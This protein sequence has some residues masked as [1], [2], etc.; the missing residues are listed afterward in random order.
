[1]NPRSSLI[2]VGVVAVLAGIAFGGWYLLVGAEEPAPVTLDDAL[3]G[4]A[5]SPVAAAR[6]VS[7]TP[8]VAA[9]TTA[10]VAA[11][12]VATSAPAGAWAVEGASSFVGYRINEELARIGA[13]TVV[14]R[15]SGVTGQ[16][17]YNG[18]ALTALKVTADMTM[19]KTNETRRDNFLR[20]EGLET[21]K[22]PQ[23]VFEL[24]E[25]IAVSV[26]ITEGATLTTT[27]KGDLTV[28][29]VT[30]RVE[31]PV[32]GKLAGGK[33]VVV[34]SVKVALAD[35]AIVK[36][37]VPLVLSIEDNAVVEL[38]LVFTPTGG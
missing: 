11:P 21:N 17:T 25:P 16:L 27:A 23:A 15:T 4:I 2:A 20:Q 9:P 26:T 36:P 35:F 13:N 14:G 18:G 37:R 1:M 31:V 24:K 32:E 8:A 28:H 5:A 38:S 10:T 12:A 30:R 33:L 6:G 29:G 3:K 34:G 22:F 7:T 19:L